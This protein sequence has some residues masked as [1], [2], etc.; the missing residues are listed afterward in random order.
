MKSKE[1]KLTITSI[2]KDFF[3]ENLNIDLTQE[4]IVHHV[5]T[6]IPKAMDPWRT[7]RKLY[8]EGWLIQV[9]KGVYRR[10]PNYNGKNNTDLFTKKIKD[11]I[12]KRDEYK[13]V[14]CGNGLHN[15]YDIHVDHIRPQAK[16]GKSDLE[17]G[18]IL[19]SEHNILKKR[20]GTVEFLDKYCDK[21]I[22][23]S[24]NYKDKKTEK[25]FFEIKEVLKK[26]N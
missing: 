6:K 22:S 7:V 4:K 3:E 24:K 10:D 19:C 18:Q 11:E 25:M 12:F 14:I 15:G 1:K 8:Q 26:Y 23:K 5:W 21:M 2:I 20:Y 13:C 16:G 9:K 17:N